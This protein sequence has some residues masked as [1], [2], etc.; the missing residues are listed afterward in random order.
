MIS[1]FPRPAPYVYGCQ[2]CENLIKNEL[3][4]S[5]P[6]LLSDQIIA[7]IKNTDYNIVIF[8]LKI[9]FQ[10][11]ESNADDFKQSQTIIEN[12]INQFQSQTRFK[13]LIVQ[14]F[15]KLN[16]FPENLFDLLLFQSKFSLSLFASE[17]IYTE[18][19]KKYLT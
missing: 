11:L 12:L 9:L 10:K 1:D 19:A 16:F 8:A 14:Y 3:L 17:S 6:S 7:I 15:N 18:E 13:N 5:N 4:N 2:Y